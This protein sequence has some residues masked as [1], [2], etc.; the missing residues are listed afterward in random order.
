MSAAAKPAPCPL[1]EEA[2]RFWEELVAHCKEQTDSINACASHHGLSPDDFVEWIPGD[3][4][5]MRRSS[6]PSTRVDAC[7]D[8]RP[9]CPT[10]R[11]TI[12]GD[13]ADDAKFALEEFEMLIAKD[14]DGEVVAVYEEGKSLSPSDVAMYLTQ[15]FRRC[16]PGISLYE[17]A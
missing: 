11:G 10:I 7:L 13:E 5:Q 4:I 1:Y 17:S 3:R 8:F 6:L 14:I 16:F 2:T 12:C 15:N 9:W